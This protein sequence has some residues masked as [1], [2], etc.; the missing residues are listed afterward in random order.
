MVIPV[1]IHARPHDDMDRV[2]TVNEIVDVKCP[3]FA[4][5]FD[6][7]GVALCNSCHEVLPYRT[8]R[9]AK[10]NMENDCV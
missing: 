5:K 7:D 6:D 2:E 9:H 8:F 10:E 4:W 1:R 3:H